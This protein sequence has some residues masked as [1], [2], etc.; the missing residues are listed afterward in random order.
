L[1]DRPWYKNWPKGLPTSLDYP[2]VPLYK[3]LESSAARHPDREAIIF[4]IGDAVTTYGELWDKAQR[5]ATALARMGVKKGDRVA[6]QMINNPLTA[7]A[8][9][10]ILRAG[11]VYCPC[12][13]LLSYRELHHQLV[14]TGAETFIIFEMF[15]D[16]FEPIRYDTQ[17]KRLIVSGISEMLQPPTPTDVKPYGR[18]TYS[19]LSLINDTPS[20]PPDIEFDVENDLAH[21]AYTGGTTGVPKGVMVTH[22]NAVVANIQQA[23]W[24]MGGRPVVDDDGLL[25]IVDPIE[26]DDREDWDYPVGPAGQKWLVIV[27]WSH[28][29]G[30][31]GYLNIPVYKGDT[32]VVHPRLEMP[33]Y[34]NDLV[35]H[36]CTGCG[37]APQLL[38]A[39]L[40]YPGI[41][42]LDLSN[43]RT[44]G[45]GAAPLPVDVYRGLSKLLP[46][47]LI[48]EGY[49]LTE[50]TLGATTNPINRSGMRKLGSV[51]LPV[52][53][54][55]VKIVDIDDPT[56]EIDFNEIGEV[57][58]RGPQMM[59]G[60]WK[61][62]EETSRVIID[63]WLHTGDLGYLDEDGYLF[64]VDRKKDML[65]YNGHN[66]YPRELEEILFTH[67]AVKDCAVIGKPHSLTGEIPKA[68][69]VRKPDVK[70]TEQE[71][72]D[73]VKV[74][75]ADYKQIR[76]LE[77]IDELPRNYAGKVLRR[78]LR[79]W[80]I[81][82]VA[83]GEV[84]A[85]TE[86]ELGL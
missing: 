64:L 25:D 16:K 48:I 12:N 28:A 83:A 74:R 49:G 18:G 5:F 47:A 86:E 46:N 2:K 67:R 65:I 13:P 43:I 21:I 80:E 58:L 69:V 30:V 42:K 56:V 14:D 8:Y 68:F 36:K 84:A 63:G 31:N 66:V 53:D 22:Y 23:H 10:G 82:R 45:C 51:G 34:M 73:F 24:G 29:M 6:V 70:V 11:A 61:N 37:G 27:P 55:D 62:P 57:C 20:D 15:M 7:I 44:V 75:V 32:M 17:V 35:K 54:T 1:R 59:K 41:E 3:F 50:M 38:I 72:M 85:E 39:M 77:F 40:N 79:R 4:Q 19:L 9:Y 81:E 26:T 71:L 76:E 60:Y 78:E 33:A 52:F